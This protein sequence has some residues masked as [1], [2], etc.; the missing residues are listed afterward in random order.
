[1]RAKE[2]GYMVLATEINQQYREMLPELQR[3]AHAHAAQQEYLLQSGQG[4][5]GYISAEEFMTRHNL[6]ATWRPGQPYP[7]ESDLYSAPVPPQPDAVYWCDTC[8]D[9]KLVKHYPRG[10]IYPELRPC[11]DCG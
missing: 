2:N 9:A 4:G 5:L 8:K 11:P 10:R 7:P 1:M 6:P 3:Q